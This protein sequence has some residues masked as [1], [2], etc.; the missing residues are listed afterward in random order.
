VSELSTATPF[1]DRIDVEAKG[2]V[3]EPAALAQLAKVRVKVDRYALDPY[4]ETQP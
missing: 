3:I 2:P 4:T 1:E